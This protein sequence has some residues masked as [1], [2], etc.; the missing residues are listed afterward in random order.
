LAARYGITIV[1]SRLPR[2]LTDQTTTLVPTEYD[3]TVSTLLDALRAT[4]VG[5]SGGDSFSS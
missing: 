3:D 2:L 5:G 4:F 1:A